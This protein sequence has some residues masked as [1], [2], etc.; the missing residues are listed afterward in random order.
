[1]NVESFIS[2]LSRSD[3]VFLAGLVLLLS[4]ASAVS[5]SEKPGHNPP[6]GNDRIRPR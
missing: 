3:W 5:F 6:S 4:A 1:M 2:F